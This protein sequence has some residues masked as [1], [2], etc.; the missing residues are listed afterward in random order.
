MSKDMHEK[1]MRSVLAQKTSFGLGEISSST[2]IYNERNEHYY[3]DTY[4]KRA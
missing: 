4:T 1:W 2:A 3:F